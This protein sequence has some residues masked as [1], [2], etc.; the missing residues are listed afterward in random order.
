[1]VAGAA[2]GEVELTG[3]LRPWDFDFSMMT[4]DDT[5]KGSKW[6]V[7]QLQHAFEVNHSYW[8]INFLTDSFTNNVFHNKQY[9]DTQGMALFDNKDY[10]Y[11]E[12]VRLVHGNFV[13]SV[14]TSDRRKKARHEGDAQEV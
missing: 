9:L 10:E 11:A 5:A 14:S 1:M 12:C 13:R 6:S 3:A 4:W 2:L 8:K 7:R